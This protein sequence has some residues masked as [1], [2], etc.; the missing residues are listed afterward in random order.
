MRESEEH[1][2][3]HDKDSWT[4]RY[5]TVQRALTNMMQVSIYSSNSCMYASERVRKSRSKVSLFLI[6]LL[7]IYQE[8]MEAELLC[9]N[10]YTD[11]TRTT[12]KIANDTQIILCEISEFQ[13]ERH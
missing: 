12:P 3:T 8:I 5:C 4:R 2:I 6:G 9:V 13:E 11:V 1:L 7:L 10:I